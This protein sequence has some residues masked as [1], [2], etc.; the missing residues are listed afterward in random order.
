MLLRSY[1][2]SRHDVIFVTYASVSL[3]LNV[4]AASLLSVNQSFFTP[5]IFLCASFYVNF[6]LYI[7]LYR[8][9]ALLLSPLLPFF[10]LINRFL[11]L[12]FFCL[13]LSPLL[14]FLPSFLYL[15]P[16]SLLSPLRSFFLLYNSVFTC[17]FSI[18]FFLP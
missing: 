4:I 17:Y 11:L 3:S 6:L 9:P 2:Q 10:L 15:L 16:A 8:F 5:V 18:Y 1:V 12:L 7:F 14:F 13:L